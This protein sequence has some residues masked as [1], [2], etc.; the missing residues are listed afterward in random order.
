[1][2]KLNFKSK[3]AFMKNK[4]LQKVISG[5]FWSIMAVHIIVFTAIGLF[6]AKG[7]RMLFKFLIYLAAILLIFWLLNLY[8]KKH[9]EQKKLASFLSFMINR[10][11][12]KKTSE[13]TDK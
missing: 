1:M 13:N 9:P 7:W 10:K 6:T 2:A 8:V 11:N 12:R 5:S 3:K 4:I